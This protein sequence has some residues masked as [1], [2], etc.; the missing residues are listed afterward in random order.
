VFYASVLRC[1]EVEMDVQERREYIVLGVHIGVSIK[2]ARGERAREGRG[3]TVQRRKVYE[4]LIPCG[5]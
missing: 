2:R 4:M 1:E 5:G 3:S